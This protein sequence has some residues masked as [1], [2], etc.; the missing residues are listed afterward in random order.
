MERKNV[1]ENGTAVT[2]G[3]ASLIGDIEWNP[4]PTFKGVSMKHVIKGADTEGR[5]S[6]HLVRIEPGCEIG[7]HVHEGKMELHEVVAGD[8]HC[9]IGKERVAYAAGT[10]ACIPDDVRHSVKAGE[11]G[12]E[13]LAKFSPALI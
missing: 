2:A 5:L 1:F 13:I 8:G 3:V 9:L 7:D 4:H 6:C 12:L 11:A 10:M